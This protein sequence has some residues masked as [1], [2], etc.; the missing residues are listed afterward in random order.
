MTKVDRAIPKSHLADKSVELVEKSV[1][2]QLEVVF[3]ALR[4][5]TLDTIHS[6]HSEWYLE[7]EGISD[8]ITASVETAA[9]TLQTLLQTAVETV[10]VTI[11]NLY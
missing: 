7:P 8:T 2:M 11:I 9:D 10:Q 6:L 1:R 3:K 4:I 5:S